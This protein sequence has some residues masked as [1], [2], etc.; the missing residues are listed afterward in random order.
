[1]GVHIDT[2]LMTMG[3]HNG[4]FDSYGA[5]RP[6]LSIVIPSYRRTDLLLYCLIS[7]QR[8]APSGT[9]VI[10]VDDGSNGSAVSRV[11]SRFP[12][13]IVVRRVKRGGFCA[14]ANAGIMA[15]SG[16]IVELLNDD[17]EVTA[18]WATSAIQ[19]FAD[20][21]VAAVAPLVLQHDAERHARGMLPLI[22]SAGDDYD[23]G[24]FARKRSHG[25]PWQPARNISE[26][27]LG[28]SACAA[29]YRREVLLRAGGF[30]EH[31]R[32]YFEDV[33]LS[34]RI[35]QLGY[36]ILHVPTSIVWHRGS[37][38]YGRTPSIATLT[39]QSCN[40]ERVFW[41]NLRGR[42]RL[43]WL[44]RHIAVLTGK[45]LR[46]WQEGTLIPWLLGRVRAAVT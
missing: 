14:A 10:V 8:H 38:S 43:R 7:V 15:S 18:G 12:S 22:D 6:V 39:Q 41:R 35:R 28:A 42:D 17:T 26:R 32:A 16:A 44:P 46:R 3:C 45:S 11:A 21:R 2:G 33:D 5:S 30:P 40:E 24:G 27:V 20:G 4:S 34:L 9:E 1:M 36:E 25:E 29:F 19:Q 31:F 37:A 23:F 13:V